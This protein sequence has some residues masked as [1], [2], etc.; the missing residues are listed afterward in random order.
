MLVR[1]DPSTD[2]AYRRAIAVLGRWAEPRLSSG[3]IANRADPRAPSRVRPWRPARARWDRLTSA[4]GL[5]VRA[6]V[7][8]CY[9]SIDDAVLGRALGDRSEDVVAVLRTL[10]DAGVVGLPIGPDGSALLANWVLAGVDRAI[11]DAGGESMRWVDDWAIRVPDRR[12][13]G[14]V[15]R[16]LERA[17]GGLGLAANPSKAAVV[18]LPQG[19]SAPAGASPC[20]ARDR[21]MMP[22]P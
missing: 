14:V 10:W 13:A 9:G 2:R 11:A 20:G 17:L 1:L 16:T 5:W 4:P 7:R 22:R 6:D 12:G 21:G 18:R 19:G 3:V 8:E 15:V